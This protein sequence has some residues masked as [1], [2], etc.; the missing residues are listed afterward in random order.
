M[1]AI[2]FVLF[3]AMPGL[4]FSVPKGTG[5]MDLSDTT[6]SGIDNIFH[7]GVST[8]H[9]HADGRMTCSNGDIS[10]NGL[11]KV[12]G[13]RIIWQVNNF[14]REFEATFRGDILICQSQN[15]AGWS[16]EFHLHKVDQG[17]K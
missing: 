8:F 13:Y 9:F 15:R 1:R 17:G 14:Y 7:E 5:D 2:L 3:V 16:N 11:W 10:C 4:A 12:E 6:W